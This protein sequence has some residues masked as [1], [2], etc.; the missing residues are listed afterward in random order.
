MI[1]HKA[2]WDLLNHELVQNDLGI[3][4]LPCDCTHCIIGFKKTFKK[5][6]C[7]CTHMANGSAEKSKPCLKVQSKWFVQLT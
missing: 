3:K 1:A 7:D 2:H 5:R 6:S 4:K